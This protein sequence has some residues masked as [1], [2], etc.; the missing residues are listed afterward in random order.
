MVNGVSHLATFAYPI[1]AAGRPVDPHRLHVVLKN[2]HCPI[3][4]C[5]CLVPAKYIRPVITGEFA[6]KHVFACK[7]W[8]C[9]YWVVIEDLLDA[10]EGVLDYRFYST[11][12]ARKALPSGYLTILERDPNTIVLSPSPSSTSSGKSPMS[13]PT[14]SASS[15]FSDGW[16]GVRRLLD[17]R[18]EG[19]LETFNPEDPFGL[20]A[21]PTSGN[22]F[23]AYPELGA[24]KSPLIKRETV[25]PVLFPATAAA[26]VSPSSSI[27]SAGIGPLYG[28]SMSSHFMRITGQ[29]TYTL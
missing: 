9:S 20:L 10:T 3:P 25:S 7:T 6:G 27:S 21:P 2:S 29:L 17:Y 11:R 24:S 28:A 18:R 14:P 13:A 12:G 16:S 8:S 26:V 15:S 23:P 19:A 5:F 4:T 22:L 1:T